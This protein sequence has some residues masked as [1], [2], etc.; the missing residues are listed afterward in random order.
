MR[1]PVAV[2]NPESQAQAQAQACKERPLG[3]EL[4][5]LTFFFLSLADVQS[6]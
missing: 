5:I 1:R 3:Q 2:T 6:F 4:S